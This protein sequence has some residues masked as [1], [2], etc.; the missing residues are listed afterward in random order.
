MRQLWQVLFLAAASVM[1]LAAC[2]V[3]DLYDPNYKTS[4]PMADIE[5]DPS[6]D[7][8]M[9][10]NV[11]VTVKVNDDLN[12][13][14]YY[15]VNIYK[16]NPVTEAEPVLLTGGVAKKGQD[17]QANV[18]LAVGTPYLYVAQTDPRGRT[19]VQQFPVESS[20][21]ADFTKI[22][23]EEPDATFSVGAATRSTIS[24]P[25]Y[26]TEDAE[27][28]NATEYTGGSM[29]T[30]RVY[31]ISAGKTVNAG[32]NLKLDG[33]LYVAGTLNGQGITLQSGKPLIVLSG[34]KVNDTG[35]FANNS[36]SHLT[37]MQ[38]GEL[39]ANATNLSGWGDTYVLGSLKV[40]TEFRVPSS[41]RDA[42]NP[43]ICYIGSDADITCDILYI[44]NNKVYIENNGVIN[45]RTIDNKGGSELYNTCVINVS[46]S[47]NLNSF[48]LVIFDRGIM[49]APSIDISSM[50]YGFTLRNGSMLT[51]Y[52][53]TKLTITAG[54]TPI[55]GGTGN[56]S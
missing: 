30:N 9:T 55:L 14:F 42:A 18:A 43:S 8:N 6:L 48:R 34:G 29:Q 53:D 38:G 24:V 32:K 1:L 33:T 25:A 26:S 7:W 45:C 11:P 46:E 50:S 37:I 40:A 3:K 21:D 13:E 17:F 22:A 16:E 5:V 39:T 15:Q 20:V 28:K 41:N 12:G 2:D 23:Y 44:P 54:S 52:G 27:F 31:K 56:M 51:G 19:V 36:D 10:T 4:N 47:A 49:R 35:T